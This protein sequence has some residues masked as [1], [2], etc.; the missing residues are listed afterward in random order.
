VQAEKQGGRP[1]AGSSHCPFKRFIDN[2]SMIDLGFA[3]N[4]FTWSNNRQG[5]ENIKE[6]LDRGLASPS[7]IH[8]HPE[9]CMIHL[10]A[11]NSDHNPISLNTNSTSCFLARPFRFKEFWTKNP[12]CG[13]VIAAAWK[14]FVPIQQDFCLPKK[15][16]NTKVALLK[17]NS[18]HFG[19]IHKQI[20]DTLKLLDITQKTTPSHSSFELEISL[21]VDLDNLLIKEESLWRSKSRESW[22]TYKDLS[23]KYF[24]LSTLIRRRSNAVNF[25]KLDSGVWVSSRTEIG[26]HF[27]AHFTNIFTSTNPHIEPE[28]Q[29]LFPLI[30]I[31]EENDLLSSI[32]AE[33][34]ILDALA[35]LGSTK[36]PGPDGFTALFFKKYSEILEKMSYS[37]F[38]CSSK[39]IFCR[40]SR[41]T[42]SLHWFQ[43]SVVLTL[44]TN[45]DQ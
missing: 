4:P 45:S 12:S 22:L 8:L 23:T 11:H 27:S 40:G 42:P 28:M 38:G 17:W 7:W 43:N 2:F 16:E 20:N 5:L 32:P 3:G 33:E 18:L 15:L 6:R 35:S 34:E 31:E 36:A 1:V 29:N 25:L 26:D 30:I 41:I 9:F 37:A 10:P 39:E 44:L 24:H 14:K 19:N 13:Q 21:K